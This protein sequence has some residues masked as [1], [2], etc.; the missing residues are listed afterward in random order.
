T[1]QLGTI[2]RLMREAEK[3]GTTLVIDRVIGCAAGPSIGGTGGVGSGTGAERACRAGH[4]SN[5]LVT[6]N[7]LAMAYGGDEPI[8]REMVVSEYVRRTA[9]PIPPVVV[10][11]G[12]VQDVVVLGDEIDVGS[13]PLLIHSPKDAGRYITAG[14]V[15][16]KDPET[17]IRNVSINRMQLK[18]PRKLGIR[19]MSPQHLGQIYDQC[20]RLGRPLE[21]AVVIGNHPLELI[22]ATTSVELGVDELGLAGAL[23]GEPLQVVRCRTVDLEVP[24]HAEVVIEGEVR[25]GEREAE[26]PFG[27]FMQYYVPVMKN[28]VLHVRAVTHRRDPLCAAIKAGSVEDTHLL[29]SSREAAILQ[30]VRGTGSEVVAVHLGPTIMN[31]AISIRKQHEA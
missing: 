7:H 19:M 1:A 17:G 24:A 6:P 12:P 14:M 16:A 18:G 29:A 13:F 26:G 8:I 20:E 21:V 25:P 27:D 30:A 2:P 5:V 31:C 23:R 10:A 11:A 22:A 3:A 4:V 9:T 15:I 28:H